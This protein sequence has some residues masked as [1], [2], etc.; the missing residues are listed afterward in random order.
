MLVPETELTRNRDNQ[1]SPTAI[2]D[3]VKMLAAE[4]LHNEE[5]AREFEPPH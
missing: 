4:G 1:I 5:L 2:E 3:L